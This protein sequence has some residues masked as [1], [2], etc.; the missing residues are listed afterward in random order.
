M[1]TPEPSTRNRRLIKR[2][3]PKRSTKVTCRK[4]ALGL[5]PNLALSLL[6]VSETGVRLVVKEDFKVRQEVEITLL[7]IGHQ[8]PLQLMGEVT[9]CVATADGNH[10][11]GVKFQRFLSYTDLQQ[12]T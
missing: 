7:G 1:S 4:G 3:A 12:L 8:R 6:D 5:G 2:R 10:C 9:W 11:V